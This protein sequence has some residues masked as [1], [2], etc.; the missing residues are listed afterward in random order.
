MKLED[1][2]FDK[3]DFFDFSDGLS[4]YDH[5]IEEWVMD[6]LNKIKEKI[7]EQPTRT[8]FH[9]TCS[10]GNTMVI[11]SVYRQ[12]NGKFTVNIDVT[13]NYQECTMVDFEF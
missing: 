3:S 2:N 11:I 13:N 5:E 12:R 1:F 6:G 7:R 10:T 9:Y 4:V 8:D